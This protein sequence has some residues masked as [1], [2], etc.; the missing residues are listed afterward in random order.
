MKRD[1]TRLWRDPSVPQAGRALLE[2]ARRHPPVRYDVAAG[3]ARFRAALD[4]VSVT[5]SAAL[6]ASHAK[7]ALWLKAAS[8]LLPS[9]VAVTAAYY[10]LPQHAQPASRTP[11]AAL[12]SSQQEP[13]P[14]VIVISLSS[15]SEAGATPATPS[16]R[17]AAQLGAE[18]ET[19][20]QQ[21]SAAQRAAGVHAQGSAR[22][23]RRSGSAQGSRSAPAAGFEAAPNLGQPE[24]D[25]RE[26]EPRR[27]DP[28]AERAAAAEPAD[29][30]DELRGIARARQLVARNPAAALALLTR[31]SRVHPRGYFVEER[32]ALT[33]LA[34]SAE[35]KRERAEREAETFLR[36][37]PS[38]P[39]ADRVRAAGTH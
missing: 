3:A 34:L 16:E 12:V 36:N 37:H 8:L 14:A 19:A 9:A 7:A 32:E 6:T 26:R 1:P 22:S 24:P 23:Q 39:F 17:T 10:V 28:P 2:A 18:R 20:G 5:Q 35:G 25:V 21:A 29:S 31:L 4:A 13:T 11:P 30:L 15:A 38:S 27:P 33:V